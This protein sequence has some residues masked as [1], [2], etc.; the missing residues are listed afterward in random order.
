MQYVG[1]G[2]RDSLPFSSSTDSTESFAQL[3]T[4][5]QSTCIMH[6]TILLS[7]SALT[8]AGRNQKDAE[9][10]AKLLLYKIVRGCSSSPRINLTKELCVSLQEISDISA[11]TDQEVTIEKR[12][13]HHHTTSRFVPLRY[14]CSV[15]IF[16]FPFHCCRSSLFMWKM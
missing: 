1:L 5:V 12:M 7:A 8:C 11:Q 3:I 15:Y 13:Q 14:F 6:F 4:K 10:I 16:L 2:T 9:F